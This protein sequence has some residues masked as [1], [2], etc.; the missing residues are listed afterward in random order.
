MVRRK[1]LKVGLWMV[2][3]FA[4]LAI[5]LPLVGPRYLMPLMTR[6]NPPPADLDTATTRLTEQGLYNVAFVSAI[7]PIAIN[8]I[9]SWT[10]HVENTGGEPVDN[11][12]ITVDG[13]MPQHGHGLPTRPQVTQ[14][15][16]GGDYLVDGL[17]FQMGG[18]WEVRYTIT[19]DGQTDD[20]TFN[21]VLQ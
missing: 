17:K 2:A 9:H 15:L 7:D 19:A 3:V 13:G 4:V 21:L 11:A 12:E 5:L 10:L 6:F 16:G 14:N 8:Q 20:I 18:W 1:I